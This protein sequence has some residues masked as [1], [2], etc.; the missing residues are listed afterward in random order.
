M[1]KRIANILLVVACVVLASCGG[2]SVVEPNAHSEMQKSSKRGV[3][4]NFTNIEDLPLLSPACSWAYNWGNSQ[5]N[6]AAFWFD[7]ND[8]GYRCAW[9]AN[10]NPIY[11]ICK[12]VCGQTIKCMQSRTKAH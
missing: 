1:M 8:M 10:A 12:R 5:N 7:N 6:S 3:S 2:S 4:F 9:I 11:T